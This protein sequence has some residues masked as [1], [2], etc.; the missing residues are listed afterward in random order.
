MKLSRL[1]ACNISV[2]ALASAICAPA[3]AQD[4]AQDTPPPASEGP[5]PSAENEIVVT[6]QRI[7]GSVDTDVPPVVELTEADIAAYGAD[8]LT[9]LVAQLSPQ[10]GSGRGRG[11]GQPVI[12]VN[13]QRISRGALLPGDELSFASLKFQVQFG[14]ELPPDAPAERTEGM[15][16]LPKA[17]AVIEML[18]AD[19]DASSDSLD[20]FP[21]PEL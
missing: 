20:A 14:S 3:A 13:G 1:R 11:G 2:L 10:T 12:L 19:E 4:N 18:E 21:I 7:R 17:E 8:S 6:A 9:D 15:P 5:L 16:M